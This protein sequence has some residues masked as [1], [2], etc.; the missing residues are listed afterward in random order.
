MPGLVSSDT[1]Y[2][3]QWGLDRPIP[4]TPP[5]NEQIKEAKRL[6]YLIFKD[7]VTLNTI[8]KRYEGTIRKRWLKK[9]RDQRSEILL[10]AWPNMS[11]SHNPFFDALRLTT[12][13]KYVKPARNHMA[14][15]HPYINLEDLLRP[16][17]L[18]L[19]LHSRGR[20]LPDNFVD[21]DI[22]AARLHW[23]LPD[24]NE[25]CKDGRMVFYGRH[26]PRSY[27]SLLPSGRSTKSSDLSTGLAYSMKKGLVI[28][29]IQQR[30]LNFLTLCSKRIIGDI[31]EQSIYN[32]PQQGK[33][34]SVTQ[35]T[36]SE[37]SHVTA[38]SLEAP[39]RLPQAIDFVHM[40]K[41]VS[42]KRREAE[43]HIFALR[44]DPGYFAET[45]KEFS[46]HSEAMVPDSNGR[47]DPI[48][49]QGGVFGWAAGQFIAHSYG[50]YFFWT[51]LDVYV[52]DASAAL[53][54]AEPLD[55][56]K[57]LPHECECSLQRLEKFLGMMVTGPLA[58]LRACIPGSP[59]LRHAY[60][61]KG[62]MCISARPEISFQGRRGTKESLI[63]FLIDMLTTEGEVEQGLHSMDAMTQEIQYL[64][65]TDKEA[66]RLISPLMAT[67][68]SDVALLNEVN[69]QI[70]RLYPWSIAWREH[71][72]DSPELDKE[73]NTPKKVFLILK[74]AITRFCF[75]NIKEDPTKGRFFYPAEKRRTK[76]TTNAMRQAEH[77]LDEFWADA[78]KFCK[79]TIGQSIEDFLSQLCT[80]NDPERP[81]FG[82]RTLCRTPEWSDPRERDPD[83]PSIS[84]LQPRDTN[85][86]PWPRGEDSHPSDPVQPRKDKV[87]TRGTTASEDNTEDTDAVNEPDVSPKTIF[88]VKKRASK[89]FQTLFHSTT[90]YSELAW[91]DFLYAMT[92]IGFT[93]E[94]LYGSVWLFQPNT[95]HLERSIQFHEPHM[96]GK[97][98]HVMARLLGRRL[99]RA[100]GW[101]GETFVLKDD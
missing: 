95:V 82:G 22:E 81:V 13:K 85:T 34:E 71:D 40:L 87:K 45:I 88:Q 25:V 46:E 64:M 19:F 48:V 84:P 62:A 72:Y 15:V 96:R 9:T 90:E 93:A 59:P 20:L 12:K 6:S 24:T 10:T 23:N 89:A 53:Q 86:E 44:E 52:V 94:K 56:M 61:R 35:Y 42:A 91:A 11:T 38:L 26:T 49:A 67:Y 65:D 98:P 30:I 14:F 28:L 31:C 41:L 79:K 83:S 4:L 60:R 51:M 32:A 33:L 43:D 80:L 29:E 76:D 73:I 54:E 68:F 7:W 50:L 21:S 66:A 47:I 78:D 1:T 5:V 63:H 55:P 8:L 37:Y 17:N 2:A 69:L 101:D 92:S 3:L 58:M 77:N 57:D 74:G 16:R 99:N 39:Y 18:L 70:F 100:Y 36:Q 97:M 75:E 27:G